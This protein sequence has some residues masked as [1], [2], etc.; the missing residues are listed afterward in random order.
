VAIATRA[1][2]RWH[3]SFTHLRRRHNRINA[4]PRP[5]TF[6]ELVAV[7]Q[8]IAGTPATVTAF[9]REQLMATGSNYLVGQF[10]FGD[11]TPAEALHSIA[12]FGREVMPALAKLG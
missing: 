11:L 4:H 3:D 5:P 2:P 12:L 1:Y 8:G 6:A 9:L 7:G 10:A